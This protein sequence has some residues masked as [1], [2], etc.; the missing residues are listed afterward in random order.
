MYFVVT[1]DA[2][3]LFETLDGAQF[4]QICTTKYA[5][6]ICNQLGHRYGRIVYNTLKFDGELMRS[7]PFIFNCHANVDFPQTGLNPGFIE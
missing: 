2:H 3:C 4:R 1:L 6:A 7:Q 5:I